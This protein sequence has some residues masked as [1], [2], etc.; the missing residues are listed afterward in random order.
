MSSGWLERSGAAQRARTI[1]RT[2]LSMRMHRRPRI[3]TSSA[4]GGAARTHSWVSHAMCGAG[5]R[6][7]AESIRNINVRERERRYGCVQGSVGSLQCS[8]AKGSILS[9][10]THEATW[11]KASCFSWPAAPQPRGDELPKKL[12]PCELC[13]CRA[14]AGRVGDGQSSPSR[15]FGL[16]GQ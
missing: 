1:S 2:G 8:F 3:T 13:A 5:R 10:P 6:G 4:C 7:R 15:A 14:L 11:T 16:D 9:P 12:R